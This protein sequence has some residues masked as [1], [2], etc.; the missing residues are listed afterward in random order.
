[1]CDIM[2]HHMK[3]Y[4]QTLTT[5]LVMSVVALCTSCISIC[6]NLVSESVLSYLLVVLINA[7]KVNLTLEVIIV[8]V[9]FNLHSR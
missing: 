9:I 2:C 1:M 6:V 3:G 8:N 5:M 4:L 7:S